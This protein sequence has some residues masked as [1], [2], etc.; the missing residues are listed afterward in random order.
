MADYAA[1]RRLAVRQRARARESTYLRNLDWVLLAAVGGIVAYGLWVISGITKDDIPGNPNYYVVRQAAYALVGCAGLAGMTLIDPGFWRKHSRIVYGVLIAM[2]VL[3]PVL[4][5]SVRNTRR[6]IDFGPFRF[7]PSEFGKLLLVLFLA[8]FLADR[9]KRIYER[10]TTLT[11]VGLAA[12]PMMLVFLQ[13]DF[14]T[15]IVYAGI[16]GAT[17]FIAGTRWSQ[18]SLLLAVG[19]AGATFVL[20][21]GPGDRRRRPQAVPART[22]HR[23]R[24]PVA[25]SRRLDVQHHAVDHRG[26]RG[27][28]QRPRA[29]RRDA[30]ELQLPAR[31][32]DRLRLRF[33]RRAARF[34]RRHD[35][36][37]A[38]PA[39]D[40]AG[41]QGDHARAGRVRGHRRGRDRVR[42]VGADLHQRRDDDRDGADHGH[43][44]S[45]RERGRKLDGREP[46]RDRRPPVHLRQA[47]VALLTQRP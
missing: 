17:L 30:D 14:G 2:L 40:L 6:W 39:R 41:D 38:L 36:A 46:A 10:R 15:A 21:A 3:T 42:A 5:S 29:E 33:D 11:A 26:R 32:R 44:A 1:D 25:G 4:G 43:S 45:V 22:D 28:G 37:P 7:Q 34:L 23:L 19:L 35:P 9:G 27:R 16:L 12:L 18:V 31:A 47:Q 20:W 13:P 24:E 8:A